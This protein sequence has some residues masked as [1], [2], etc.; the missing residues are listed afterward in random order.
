[1]LF[2]RIIIK[3]VRGDTIDYIQAFCPP[4]RMFSD[5][6]SCIFVDVN[7]KIPGYLH[8]DI[9]DLSFKICNKKNSKTHIIFK[10]SYTFFFGFT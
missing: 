3:R 2:Y 6:L 10:E 7:L 9:L 4:S 8:E 5:K 1:M